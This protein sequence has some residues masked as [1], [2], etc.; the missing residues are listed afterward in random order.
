MHHC[1][2]YNEFDSGMKLIQINFRY[3]FYFCGIHILLYEI[4]VC[5][6]HLKTV[7]NASSTPLTGL[8]EAVIWR[9]QTR[10]GFSF[11][12]R[13]RLD[14][15]PRLQF[16][17]CVPFSALHTSVYLH[18]TK[19]K[20]WSTRQEL[21]LSE[22]SFRCNPQF[23]E[24]SSLFSMLDRHGKLCCRP[25]L[26]WNRLCSGLEVSRYKTTYY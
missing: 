16:G 20:P 19:P 11:V 18:G 13:V 10:F 24:S 22:G 2:E 23:S 17:K 12:S 21:G 5:T 6:Y 25:N 3:L 4:N 1:I 15:F 8:P 14:L 7:A 26:L 9:Q